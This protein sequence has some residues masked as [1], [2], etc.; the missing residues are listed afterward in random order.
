M[1]RVPVAGRAMEHFRYN[2]HGDTSASLFVHFEVDVTKVGG[3][4]L[5]IMLANFVRNL[6]FRRHVLESVTLVRGWLPKLVIASDSCVAPFR[7][8]SDLTRQGH[9]QQKRLSIISSPVGESH[10]LEART[11]VHVAQRAQQAILEPSHEALGRRPHAQV[12]CGNRYDLFQSTN[13]LLRASRLLARARL[14]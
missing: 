2:H 12:R 10:M 6:Q 5:T 1:Y 11:P 9:P 4:C 14:V 13:N 3:H 8:L 7:Q